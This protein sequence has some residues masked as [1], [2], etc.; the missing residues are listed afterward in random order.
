MGDRQTSVPLRGLGPSTLH[1][2]PREREH[3]QLF[4]GAL[5]NKPVPVPQYCVRGFGDALV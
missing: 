1:R 2:K 5:A 3:R 4:V